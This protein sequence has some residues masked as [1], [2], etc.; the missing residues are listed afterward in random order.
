MRIFPP[1]SISAKML[2][3]ALSITTIF[4]VTTAYLVYQIRNESDLTREIAS[5]RY[6]IGLAV[7]QMEE[8]LD[9]VQN[10]IRRFKA[11]G[12]ETAARFIVEDLSRFGEILR[13]TLNR[14]PQYTEDWKPLTDEFTIS[15]TKG[16]SP[17]DAFAAD[18]TIQHWL[19]ILAGT[20]IDN[21]QQISMGMSR[22]R[23]DNVHA[24]RVGFYGLIICLLL[25][26]PGSALF[27]WRINAH[28]GAIR[29]GIHA[30][31]E[32]ETPP[33][34]RV[35]TGDELE[36]LADAFNEMAGQLHREER[37]RTDFISMLSHEI[38]TPLTSIRESVDMM[39]DGVFGPV[40]ERQ[41]RFLRIAEKETDRLADLLRRLMTVTRME[42]GNLNLDRHT[43]DGEELV[44]TTMDRLESSAMAK[45]IRLQSEFPEAETTLLGDTENLRQVLLNLGGNAIKFS[46]DNSR[47][48]FRLDRADNGVVFSVEDQGP[49]VPEAERELI[50]KKYYRAEGVR[51]DKDGAGL[52]LAICH[53]IVEAHGG[54]MWVDSGLE[55]GCA[56]RFF[57][58]AQDSA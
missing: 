2:A 4:C 55:D 45:G 15:L 41:T 8:R 5:T 32:G 10:N 29:S 12:D 16:D 48:T 19:A 51:M 7:Q 35:E 42:A 1:M 47:V 57:I 6:E 11:L 56:F 33:P 21:Q 13:E 54:H 46:P 40:N 38:R 53:K 50:F 26:I 49:G 52:G 28:L 9:S 58:P 31:G 24:Y 23:R 34:V 39:A 44:R 22:L 17:D 25:A 37:M 36:E 27:A 14:H 20:R 30:L 3:W 18:A 43:V